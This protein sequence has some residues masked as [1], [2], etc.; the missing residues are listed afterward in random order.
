MGGG[1]DGNFGRTKGRRSDYKIHHGRQN[2]HIEGTNNYKQQIANE[3]KPSILTADP[4]Q[5]LKE[6]AGRGTRYGA[7]KTVVDYGKIIGKFYDIRTG[8]YYDTTRATIHYDSKGNA[9]IVPAKP[10]WLK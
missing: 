6:G 2:K 8:M 7:N 5:L 4:E 9:H 3:K 10:S 1:I